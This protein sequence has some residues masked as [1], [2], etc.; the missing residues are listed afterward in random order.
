MAKPTLVTSYV[1]T[2]N[3]DTS[4]SVLG[5][6]AAGDLCVVVAYNQDSGTTVT[7]GGQSISSTDT[8]GSSI[9]DAAATPHRAWV[10]SAILTTSDISTAT[11]TLTNHSTGTRRWVA[12]VFRHTDGWASNSDRVKDYTSTATSSGTTQTQ[13]AADSARPSLAIAVLAG[14]SP[15]TATIAWDGGTAVNA[16]NVTAGGAIGANPN[17]AGSSS[18]TGYDTATSGESAAWTLTGSSSNRVYLT[19]C[20]Q[21]LLHVG[22]VTKARNVSKAKAGAAVTTPVRSPAKARTVSNAKAAGTAPNTNTRGSTARANTAN[23]AKASARIVSIA[24]AAEVSIS[25]ATGSVLNKSVA[26]S[27]VASAAKA[28]ALVKVGRPA[29]ARTVDAARGVAK[30]SK[31]AQVKARTITAARALAASV[32][33]SVAKARAVSA[34]KARAHVFPAPRDIDLTCVVDTNWSAHI[35]QPDFDA[36]TNTN[37]WSAQLAVTSNWEA[38]VMADDFEAIECSV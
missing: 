22:A 32:V 4:H 17:I 25:F 33:H 14:G 13:A 12:Y 31:A 36:A 10:W 11:V 9:A 16:D 6:A 18:A 8:G 7:I 26:K 35:G 34:G 21:A 37:D 29:K 3:T 15:S 30:T 1:S 27:R 28:S 5:S 2:S 23:R 19:I 38:A 24:K 20:Y